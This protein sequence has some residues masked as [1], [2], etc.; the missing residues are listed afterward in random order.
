ML[1]RNV[2]SSQILREP[3]FAAQVPARETQ[4]ASLAD[5]IRMV[6]ESIADAQT[7]LDRASAGLVAEL[8]ETPIEVIPSIRE[9]ID[10]DGSVSYERADPVQVSLLDVGVMPT[11]YQFSQT[12]IEIAMDLKVTETLDESGRRSGRFALLADTA[13]VR[14]ERKL[15]RDVKVSSKVTAT[16]VPVPMPLRLEPVRTTNTPEPS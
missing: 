11:F 2:H 10:E 6:A 16:L 5:L 3:L 12:V 7:A 9:I 14:F 13:G 15:N 1:L 8:A 4:D